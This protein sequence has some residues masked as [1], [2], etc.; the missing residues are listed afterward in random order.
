LYI[1]LRGLH[2]FDEAGDASED[3]IVARIVSEAP[4]LDG[5]GWEDVDPAAAALVGRM[6]EKRAADRPTAAE[7]LTDPWL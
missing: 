5:A 3:E 7:V 4:T 2:P 1:L 6:L